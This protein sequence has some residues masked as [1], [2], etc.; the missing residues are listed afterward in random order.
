VKTATKIAA[1]LEKHPSVKK[2]YYP[3]LVSHEGCGL[4]HRQAKSA[5]AVLSFELENEEALRS[6]VSKVE[7]PV[8]AVS[9]G[10]VESILSYPAKMSHAAMPEEERAKRGISNALLRLSVGLESDQDLLDDF[11]KALNAT[12]VISASGNGRV[13]HGNLR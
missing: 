10:A 4:Q 7:I 3:G 1:F 13:Y 12:S 6:F 9:L 11:E 8:F 2:V 5:G